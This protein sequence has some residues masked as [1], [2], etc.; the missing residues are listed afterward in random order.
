MA[1]ATLSPTFQIVI[2]KGSAGKAPSHAETA[3][4]HP[5]EGWDHHLGAGSATQIVQGD[6]QGHAQGRSQGK[7][8]PIVKVLIDSRF[9]SICSTSDL[10][11]MGGSGSLR[12][13]DHELLLA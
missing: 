1:T 12:G 13:W 3:S 4:P 7:E 8:G 9:P 6:A 2:P 11:P 5:G 10:L